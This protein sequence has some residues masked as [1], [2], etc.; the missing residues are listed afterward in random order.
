METPT[1]RRC[2]S[3]ERSDEESAPLLF[4]CAMLLV[5]HSRG[6]DTS[7][8]EGKSLIFPPL[9]LTSYRYTIRQSAFLKVKQQRSHQMDGSPAQMLFQQPRTTPAAAE[10]IPHLRFG[11]TAQ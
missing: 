7:A 11:M 9:D 3:E 6:F 5:L 8:D 1:P 2:H 4:A 10:Q